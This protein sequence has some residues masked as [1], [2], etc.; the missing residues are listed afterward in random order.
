MDSLDQAIKDFSNRNGSACITYDKTDGKFL[1]EVFLNDVQASQAV[2]ANESAV[3]IFRKSERETMAN[4]GPKTKAY[5]LEFVKL[6]HN[7]Y[8]PHEAEYHLADM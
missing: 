4:I 8:E 3:V 1:T 6:L 2:K 5:I 7:G